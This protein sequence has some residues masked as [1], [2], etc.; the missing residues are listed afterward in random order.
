MPMITPMMPLETFRSNERTVAAVIVVELILVNC[1]ELV[2]LLLKA[3]RRGDDS[4]VVSFV[5]LLACPGLCSVA[6][7]LHYGVDTACVLFGA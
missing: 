5:C 3:R 4:V 1:L 2:A 6:Y 7:A